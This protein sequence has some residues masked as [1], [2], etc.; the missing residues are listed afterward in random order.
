MTIKSLPY[1]T[2]RNSQPTTFKG[3]AC[4][5]VIDGRP[6]RILRNHRGGYR[7]ACGTTLPTPYGVGTVKGYTSEGDV[8]VAITDFNNDYE[9][10]L[11]DGS[12]ILTA[13]E[14]V[15]MLSACANASI[16]STIATIE[17]LYKSENTDKL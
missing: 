8:H 13:Q 17:R 1:S 2:I 14:K 12:D 6:F 4:D 5:G 7:L 9:Y 10:E 15:A 16:D 3:F 11:A